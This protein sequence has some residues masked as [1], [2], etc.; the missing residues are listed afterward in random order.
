MNSE[1]KGYYFKH[2]AQQQSSYLRSRLLWLV[3]F[4]VQRSSCRTCCAAHAH[5]HARNC[6]TVD[7]IQLI[8]SESYWRYWLVLN[9]I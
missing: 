6:F 2:C 1:F 5:A 9:S 7:N 3:Y 8:L 4:R